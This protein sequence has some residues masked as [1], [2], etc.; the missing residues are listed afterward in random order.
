MVTRDSDLTRILTGLEKRSLVERRRS[1]ADRRSIENRITEKGLA[2]M[3]RLDE[4][5]VEVIQRAL[6]HLGPEKLQQ[7]SELLAEV[8]KR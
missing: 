8:R 5:V 6:H 4:P 1:I 7:L 2:L 3:G